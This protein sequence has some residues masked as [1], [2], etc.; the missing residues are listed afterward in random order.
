MECLLYQLGAD[1]D[2]S[3]QMVVNSYVSAI[4]NVKANNRAGN[5]NQTNDSNSTPRA[6]NKS[7]AL[8]SATS[9]DD[10]NMN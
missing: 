2:I 9:G 5:I 4:H 1:G 3:L 10:T 8:Y 7:N 6:R